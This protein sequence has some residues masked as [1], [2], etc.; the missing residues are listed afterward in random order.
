MDAKTP[1]SPVERVERWPIYK[2][3]A[4]AKNPRTHS[5]EQIAKIAESLTRFGQAQLIVIDDKGEIIAGH[6]R[7]AAAESLGWNEVMVGIAV[8][9]P[10]ERKR[11]YRIADNKIGLES[12][13]DNE[14]LL[15]E[16]TYLEEHGVEL[17]D[18]TG[19]TNLEIDALSPLLAGADT[20]ASG[21]PAEDPYPG[22]VK[23][24]FGDHEAR[25][26]QAV[27]DRFCEY[28]K[29][30]REDDSVS[31]A[32]ILEKAFADG[33]KKGRSRKK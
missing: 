31:I 15:E 33:G 29:N 16:F 22:M 1:I 17:L 32:T 10:E 26:P 25:V 13:W 9:W 30:S 23:F 12:G 27:Y 5:P 6:G 8:D 11:A 18:A 14:L 2:L 28:M 24:V 7:L 19:F 20:E 4:Y 21:A 3:K